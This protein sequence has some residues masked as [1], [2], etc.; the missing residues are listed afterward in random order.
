[1]AIEIKSAS[2]DVSKLTNYD[3]FEYISYVVRR[4]DAVGEAV[5]TRFP[6]EVAALKTALQE[7]DEVIVLSQKSALTDQ[8]AHY[9]ALRDSYVSGYKKFV[10]S[11]L[12]MPEG[13]ELTAAKKLDQH[14]T[15]F[16]IN[17]KYALDRE[18]GMLTNFTSDLETKYAAEIELLG[19]TMF[20]NKIKEANEKVRELLEQRDH[21]KSQYV[22]G[23]TEAARNK[24]DEVYEDLV[25]KINAAC[26]LED[27]T[28]YT[29][30]IKDVNE[31]IERLNKNT[32]GSSGDKK[33]T[34]DKPE[35]P[36]GSDTPSGDDQPTTD[37]DEDDGNDGQPSVED[38]G[39]E[40]EDDDRPVTDPDE[41]GEDGTG[42]DDGE[43]NLPPVQ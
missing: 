20:A 38:P 19:A 39:H 4:I 21:E 36:D 6:D 27:E 25:K 11:F 7:E 18:T 23:A 22:K 32:S 26:I 14:I 5:S 40:D 1:M 29:A 28:D 8:I 17:T 12:S 9:D 16:K 42:N 10:K 31:R 43:E 3:H 15:D 33:P 35:N 34:T 37:P 24:T 2:S 30:F 41:D 13:E